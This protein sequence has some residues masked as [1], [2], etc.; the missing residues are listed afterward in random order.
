VVKSIH[1]PVTENDL[2]Q[3]DVLKVRVGAASRAEL[4]RNALRV[5]IWLHAR[6]NEGYE[7]QLER[8]SEVT[9]VLPVAI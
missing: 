6:Q 1:V 3:L 5:Y 9:R 7:L 4:I 8:D 2:E